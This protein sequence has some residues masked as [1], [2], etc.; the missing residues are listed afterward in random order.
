LRVQQD[1]NGQQDIN[2]APSNGKP[3]IEDEDDVRTVSE[4]MNV[5]TMSSDS[6]VETP[7]PKRDGGSD[8]LNLVNCP[9]TL[10]YSL[11][12]IKRRP[13]PASGFTEKLT[14]R[15]ICALN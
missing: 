1:I 10:Y 5:F 9:S 15:P 11:L 12:L 13:H 3:E 7:Q 8:M 14:S 4:D 6:L 2:E